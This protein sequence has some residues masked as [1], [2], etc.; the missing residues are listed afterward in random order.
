MCYDD[1]LFER[2]VRHEMI[3]VEL[4]Q[5]NNIMVLKNA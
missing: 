5:Y 3:M 2:Q 4:Q 1:C